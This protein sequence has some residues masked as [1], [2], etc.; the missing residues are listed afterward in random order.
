MLPLSRS[1]IRKNLK[2]TLIQIFK[3]AIVFKDLQK[4]VSQKQQES[5][6]KE[7]FTRLQHKPFWIWDIEEH[8]QQDITTDG[9]CCFNHIIG[10]PQKDGI[11][12]PL[13]D[14]EE[15]ICN[16][17][18]GEQLTRKHLWI[19]K[20]TGLGVSEFMLRFMAWLTG[21]RAMS[22]KMYRSARTTAPD[23]RA[24]TMRCS[25]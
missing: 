12:K 21:D 8:K 3:V 4:L 13:Y 14:Y 18:I 19:K 20:A 22:V 24:G 9:D 25:S 7:L 6:R 17:L 2:L 1:Y 23:F 11:D 16:S 10:L 15:I 5:T